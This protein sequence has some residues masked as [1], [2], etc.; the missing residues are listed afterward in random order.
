MN[1]ALIVGTGAYVPQRVVTNAWFNE[2]LGEDVDT[3]LKENVEIY[4]R[5]WCAPEESAVDLSEKAALKAIAAAGIRPDQLNMVIVATDTPE[6]ISPS[7]AVVL[8]NRIGAINAG[9]FDVNS[10]CAGFVSAYDTACKYIQADASYRYILVVGTYAMS[11]Y[12]NIADKKTATLFADGAG[13]VVLKAEPHAESDAGY[14]A[15]YQ[16]SQGQYHDWMGIYA[17]GTKH[18]IT[19][20]IIQHKDHLL[21]FVKK[22]PKEL[23]PEMWCNIT[24]ILLDRAGVRLSDVSQFVL[25]QINVHSIR[26]TMKQLGVP[27]DRAITNMHYNGY[28][29]SAAIPMAL[30]RAVTENKIIKGDWVVMIGSGGGLSFAGAI[31]K[32]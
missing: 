20:E 18:P 8:Q 14:A 22:F 11:K 24:H 13:A 1:K 30:H 32:Y 3:W 5:H 4:E 16:I 21:K 28:T 9:S 12:L 31:F 6:Y 19:E 23:N 10:A 17:G 26:E 29:G 7:T 25:T 15:A 27:Q 2:Q